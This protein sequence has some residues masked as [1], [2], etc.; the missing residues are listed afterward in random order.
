MS[1]RT[2][3]ALDPEKVN[4]ARILLGWNTQPDAARACKV[5]LHTFARAEAGQE[6][7]RKSARL[8]AK[9]LKTTVDGL[10]SGD[11]T[12]SHHKPQAT[13]GAREALPV[14]SAG[15]GGTPPKPSSDAAPETDLPLFDDS[16]IPDA[17]ELGVAGEIT[18]RYHTH[19]G[20]PGQPPYLQ[21]LRGLERIIA[22]CLR[23][24]RAIVHHHAP[25]ES[26]LARAMR[27]AERDAYYAERRRRA[28]EIQSE[29]GDRSI[30][31][32]YLR[33]GRLFDEPAE[34]PTSDDPAKPK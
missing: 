29:R 27:D 32:R 21:R 28:A 14:Y 1:S 26:P 9:G 16:D 15:Q 23:E 22:I 30:T 11:S 13:S 34:V 31:T 19:R 24:I 18:F 4:A 25:D 2:K 5:S 12:G 6:V 3:I 33:V 10:T 17:V 8:L 20:E 7:S